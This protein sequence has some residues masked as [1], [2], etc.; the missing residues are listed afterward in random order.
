MH[1]IDLKTLRLLVAVCDHQNIKRAAA[2]AHI[3]PSAISK[4]IA[5]LEAALGTP[6][7]VRRRHGVTPTPAGAA[8]LEHARTVLF[9]LERLVADAASFAGGLKGLVRVLASP[10]AIA[11]QLPEDIAAFLRAPAHRHIQVI[12]EEAL[13]RDIVRQVRDGGAALGVCWDGVDAAGLE[14]RAY[15]GDEL[16]LAVPAGHALARR[17]RVQF[18]ETLGFDYVG[19]ASSSVV[20][21]TLQQAAARAGGALNY[22]AIVSTFDAAL[23]VVAA[24]LGVSVVSRQVAE[25]AFG[26]AAAET[27]R[28]V[29]LLPLREAWTHRRF[30]LCLR[31]YD[32]LQPA[33][34]RLVD[35]LGAR[36]AAVAA[37]MRSAE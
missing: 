13:S 2:R 5:Q 36:A 33:A 37:V 11:E 4:R 31:S 9:S 26:P 14:L 22:R 32:A 16:V 18:S 19:L 35:F 29:V 24:G 30:A 10:S 6:L 12:L 25:R 7:L 8:L 27:R 23:R 17:R 21:A 3:E 28:R 15:R 34:L 1:D 20:H